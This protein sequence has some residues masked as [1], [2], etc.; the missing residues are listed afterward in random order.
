MGS[1]PGPG[2]KVQDRLAPGQGGQRVDGLQVGLQPGSGLLSS[3]ASCR[4][5]L[6]GSV[7]G[8]GCRVAAPTGVAGVVGMTGMASLAQGAEGRACPSGERL[9]SLLLEALLLGF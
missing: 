3:L 7:A 4:V 6:I 1:I 8:T 2:G 5:G 9:L